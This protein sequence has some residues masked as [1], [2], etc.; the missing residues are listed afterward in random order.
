MRPVCAENCAPPPDQ[1]LRGRRRPEAVADQH[2]RSLSVTLR[3]AHLVLGRLLSWLVLLARSD[4]AKEPRS[5]CCGM[6]S[7]CSAKQSAPDAD[8]VDRAFLSAMARLQPAQLRRSGAPTSL[9]T[10]AA[11]LACP[12]PAAPR[13][14]EQPVRPRPCSEN[15]FSAASTLHK[16]IAR[17]EPLVT[18]SPSDH[19]GLTVV[20]RGRACGPGRV[21]GA[22]RRVDRRRVR[23]LGTAVPGRQ[24]VPGARA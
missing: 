14:P 19:P 21:H 3:L 10:N 13:R 4:A 2:D 11:A 5:S 18:R 23:W 6:G 16:W 24:R 20:R 9:T 22:Q 12:R 17:R 8:L 1:R 7:R 15:A